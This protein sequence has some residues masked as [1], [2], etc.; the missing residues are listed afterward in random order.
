VSL[1]ASTLVG[2]TLFVP[3]MGEHARVFAAALRG[4]GV[5][6][7]ACDPPDEESLRLGLS[8]VSGRECYP[9]VLTTG[10]LVKHVRRVGAERSA[11]FMPTADG[12]CR[13]GEYAAHHRRVLA[14]LGMEEVPIV[15]PSSRN[16]YSD[17]PVE[18]MRAF[19]RYAWRGF[20]LADLL[21]RTLH[22]TR[23]YEATRGFSDLAA[24]NSWRDLEDTLQ[25]RGDLRECARRI[26]RRFGS[27]ER[28]GS[29]KPRVSVVGEIYVRL[30]PFANDFVVRRIEDL[31]GEADLATFCEWID[32]TGF[33]ARYH[34]TRRRNFPAYA[35][36]ALKGLVSHADERSLSEH[37]SGVLREPVEPPIRIIVKL[38]E[39]YVDRSFGG[40]T[41]LTLGRAVWAARRGASGVVS[42]VP[43]TCMP[44][45]VASALSQKLRDDENGIPFITLAYD[46]SGGGNVG[47]RLET[48]MHQVHARFAGDGFSNVFLED[49]KRQFRPVASPL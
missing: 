1:D 38:G 20:V 6:A 31:G 7:L 49:R 39:R 34:A 43:F 10:D 3:R 8:L 47:L 42:A 36:E 28:T 37:F 11:F 33:M 23:P 15:S 32:Y 21:T 16:A 14:R 29:A 46:G 24:E 5:H 9:A 27:V 48:F 12:P 13:F 25:R 45:T 41:I 26:A 19:R 4:F 44:G 35:R 2:R 30:T 22:E 17:F 18:D 40:E